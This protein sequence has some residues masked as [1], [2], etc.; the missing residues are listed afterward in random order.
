M[1]KQ[2]GNLLGLDLQKISES[3]EMK[4]MSIQNHFKTNKDAVKTTFQSILDTIKQTKLKFDFS[5]SLE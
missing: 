5:E 3:A 4:K 1:I 2:T